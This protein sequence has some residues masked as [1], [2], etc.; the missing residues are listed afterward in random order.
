MVHKLFKANQ[1][2]LINLPPMEYMPYFMNTMMAPSR[3][4]AVKMVNEGLKYQVLDLNKKYGTLELDL[5]DMHSLL[6][7]MVNDPDTFGITNTNRAYWDDCQEKC[8]DLGMDDYI[9]WDRTHLTGGKFLPLAI[10]RM[11]CIIHL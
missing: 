9:W 2:M 4:R 8:Q 7:D 10:A 11:T 3:G 1:I 5:I 6:S